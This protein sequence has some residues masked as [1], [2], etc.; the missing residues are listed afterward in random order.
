MGTLFGDLALTDAGKAIKT[1]SVRVKDRHVKVLDR[2]AVEVNQVWNLAN[3]M[4]YE[5]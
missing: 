5:A 3:E 2:M 4:A 1:L